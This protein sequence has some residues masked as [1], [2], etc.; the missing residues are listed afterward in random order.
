MR[1]NWDICRASSQ[2]TYERC[3]RVW[4]QTPRSFRSRQFKGESGEG[5]I[6]KRVKKKTETGTEIKATWENQIMVINTRAAEMLLYSGTVIDWKSDE[7][8]VM[9]KKTRKNVNLT[10][11]IYQE[12]KEGE[13]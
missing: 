8:Q 10:C 2:N 6:L 9:D 13:L 11:Y 12:V 1:V 4:V 7:L 3:K 5:C